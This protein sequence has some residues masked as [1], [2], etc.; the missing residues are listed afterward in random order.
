MQG[1]RGPKLLQISDSIYHLKKQHSKDWGCTVRFR[2][3]ETAV[4]EGRVDRS[5]KLVGGG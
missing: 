4:E 3:G 1:G 5:G 2:R